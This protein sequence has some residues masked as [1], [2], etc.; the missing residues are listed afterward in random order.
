MW[1]NIEI[2]VSLIIFLG[3]LIFAI[4]SFYDNS[5]II[6]VGALMVALV[7]AYYMIKEIKDKKEV[8]Y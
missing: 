1:K 2:T 7:N 3:A 8:N 4:F 5:T 6:G